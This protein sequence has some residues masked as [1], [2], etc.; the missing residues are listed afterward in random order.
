M[1]SNIH[2]AEAGGFPETPTDGWWVARYS[3]WLA[4]MGAVALAFVGLLAVA[5][6]L[7]TLSPSSAVAGGIQMLVSLGFSGQQCD[8]TIRPSCLCLLKPNHLAY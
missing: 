7:I 3:S 8:T 5:F 6:N 2:A 4:S 1:A